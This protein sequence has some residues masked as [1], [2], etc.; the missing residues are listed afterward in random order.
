MR[1]MVIGSTGV[2]G[3]HL[4]PRLEAY[5]HDAVRAKVDIFDQEQLARAIQGADAVINLAT[6]V[7]RLGP[8]PDYTMNDKIRREGTRHLIDA[9]RKAGV[10]RLVQQSIAFMM[11]AGGQLMTEGSPQ[12]RSSHAAS[13]V[14]MEDLLIACDLDWIA[15]RDGLLYGPGTGREQAWHEA[16]K[17]GQPAPGDDDHYL[18]PIHVADLAEAF[19]TALAFFDRAERT[20]RIFAI[21][22]DCPL[23]YR[24]LYAR[25]ARDSKL[26]P[27]A[28]GGPIVLPSFRVSNRLAC[29]ELGWKPFY[30]TIWCGLA[31]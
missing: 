8:N 22:D 17:T 5:G 25:L 18:S 7:P 4:L 19:I 30:R 23:T 6:R 9:C 28:A 12:T 29:R 27:P 24:E 3:R 2:V 1:V 14:D 13:A 31:H 15:L 10:T 20:K 16:V 11:S 21:V 26:P